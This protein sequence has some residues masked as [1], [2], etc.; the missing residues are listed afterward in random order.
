MSTIATDVLAKYLEAQKDLLAIEA[1]DDRSAIIS[2]PLHFS[3]Y[4]R[5]ELSVTRVAVN[6]FVV[7]DMGQT[8]G[9]LKDAGFK[10]GDSVR[11]RIGDI[12]EI[13]RLRLEGN[14]LLRQCSGED[15]GNVIHEFADAAKTIGDAYLAYH[16]RGR[17]KVE[18]DLRQAVRKTFDEKRFLYKER[19]LVPGEFEQ[20]KVDFLIHPN[21]AKGLALAILSDPDRVHAEAW[22]FKTL[23]IKKTSNNKLVV[24]VLYN[25]EKAVQVSRNILERMADLAIPSTDVNR[26]ADALD[27]L[28]LSH[29]HA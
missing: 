29:G 18:H 5:V 3:A 7:S 23:D 22:G 15:L 14:T 27:T 4:T 8:I 28:D 1:I 19:Q 11:K 16:S 21:G 17:G 20:H 2:L 12:V 9:E 13:S 26:L 25:A 6:Q 24:G 10:V